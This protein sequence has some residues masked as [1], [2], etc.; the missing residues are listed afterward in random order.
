MGVPPSGCRRSRRSSRSSPPAWGCLRRPVLAP[1]VAAVLPTRVGV[2]RLRAH[3]AGAGRGPPH[4]RGGASG[5]P[6]CADCNLASSPPAWGC[7]HVVMSRG[8]LGLVLPTRVGVPPS[9]ADVRRHAA[10]PPHPRGGASTGSASRV[11][12]TE[13]SP[14]AWGCLALTVV[15]LGDELSP[16]HPR[17]GASVSA[18]CCNSGANVLPTR[19]GVPQTVTVDGVEYRR[20]P[21][22]RG[23][24]SAAVL[25]AAD[26]YQSSPPAWG[27]LLPT[28]AVHRV[29]HVLPTRVGVPP[30]CHQRDAP[31][32]PSSPPAWG[33]L[34]IAGAMN[35]LEAVL[36]TRVG[37][38]PNSLSRGSG[39]TR[40]P[41]PRGGASPRLVV[42]PLVSPSSPPAWGCL[43]LCV[44]VGRHWAVL[45]TRVGVPPTGPKPERRRRPSSPPAWGCLGATLVLTTCPRSSPPAWGCLRRRDL[46][47][48]VDCVLPTRVGVPPSYRQTCTCSPS[49]PHPRGGAS[50]TEGDKIEEKSSSPPAWGC[51]LQ[52]CTPDPRLRVLPTRVGVPPC[53]PLQP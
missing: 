25:V 17:G 40:P 30:G 37:V 15:P 16:P 9:P 32:R 5:A 4:P 18:S 44:S 42:S 22:P 46:R 14:P 26:P 3:Q 45:P 51:L 6:L 11:T 7:L 39:S 13:S 23:G 33:C 20:P 21:H 28:T 49:P 8:N 38:P 41:H 35:V 29:P 2:P 53:S 12:T 43:R 31:S 36:P 34:R 47:M 1:V 48:T 27:C 19:V 52:V 24:A 10:S 50:V